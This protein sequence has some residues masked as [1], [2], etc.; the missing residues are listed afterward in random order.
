MKVLLIHYRFFNSGG[1]ERY[2]FN[3][4]KSLEEKGI[5]V[6]PFSIINKKNNPSKYSKYFVENI[7][8]SDEVFIDKYPKT[9][10]SYIDLLGREYYSFKVKNKLKKLI[11]DTKPD[12][13]YLLVYKRSLSPSV[14]SLCN[15]NK[16]PIINRISDYNTVCGNGSLY[17]NGN[18]CDLCLNKEINCLKHKCV[19]NNFIY[20]FIRYTSIKFHKL[21]KIDSKINY[22]VCTNRFMANMMEKYGYDKNKLKIIPTFF[23][24][25]NESKLLRNDNKVNDK[26]KLLFI[27]NID[28]SKGTYDLLKAISILNG[29]KYNFELNIIGG[30]HQEEI[31]KVNEIVKKNNLD[32]KVKII[33]FVKSDE[34][35]KYYVNT[36]ITILPTRWVENLPNTLIE[37]L[38]FN[39]PVVVPNFGS[40]KYTVDDSVAFKFEALSYKSLSE[41]LEK[42]ILKPKI[43]VDKSRNCKKWFD[44]N[45]SEENHIEKLLKVF[46]E[47]SK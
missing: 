39:R 14:I 24:E 22:Y 19:K 16:I 45:F 11:K 41:C 1:P 28:E 40:F 32:D 38:Y 10:K 20:S 47:V 42:I 31:D 25:N 29:K 23:K 27:G 9:L 17:R 37:S 36:N 21:I 2:M 4:I 13:C 46:E 34:V 35:Y 8:N 43:I 26:I 6:I 30:L 7:A 44:N 5:D 18:F 12:I 33:P 3:V 15:K